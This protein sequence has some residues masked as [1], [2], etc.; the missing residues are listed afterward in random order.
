M[1]AHPRKILMVFVLTS[2]TAFGLRYKARVTC[3]VQCQRA[4][5]C[6]AALVYNLF[7]H[8]SKAAERSWILFFI[9]YIFISSFLPFLGCL[10]QLWVCLWRSWL[11]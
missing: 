8:A 4:S 7:V 10:M 2:A 11:C 9:I 5:C 1:H 6:T 3:G